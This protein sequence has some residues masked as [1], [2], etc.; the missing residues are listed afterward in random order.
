MSENRV[1]EDDH[2]HRIIEHAEREHAHE[3]QGSNPDWPSVAALNYWHMA[4]TARR[5][6]ALPHNP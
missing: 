3:M 4:Q 5:F 1:I 2:L 6:L